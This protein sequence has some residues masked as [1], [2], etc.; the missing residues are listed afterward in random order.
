M[1][2]ALDDIDVALCAFDEHDRVLAWNDTFLEFFPEHAGH[3]EVGE[4]YADNLRRFYT[5]RLSADELPHLHRYV[6]EGLERHRTQRRPYEFDHRGYRLRVS[7]I[8]LDDRGRIRVWRK[9]KD[10]V[11]PAQGHGL[12]QPQMFEV[13]TSLLLE[14]IADGIL[15]VD[16]GDLALWANRAFLRLYDLPAVDALAGLRF[17]DIY[18]RCWSGQVVTTE[19]R[20]SIDTLKENQR[21]SGAPFEIALPAARWVRVIEQR[22]EG[23]DG[24]GYFVHVDITTL[25]RQQQALHMA[26]Q[27]ARDSEARYRLLAEF[28]S[29][30]TV[31]L[32]AG[33][34]TYVS[35]AVFELLGWRPDQMVGKTLESLC[36]PQDVTYV[37]D[38]LHKLKGTPKRDYRARALRADGS[39]VWVEARARLARPYEDEGPL[40]VVN[41]RNVAARKATEDKLAQAL[42]SLKDLA[43]TDALTGVANRRRFD[44]A[45]TSEWRRAH[46]E[47]SPLA[48]MLVDLDRFKTL[49]DT[50]GHQ[51]G[52]LVLRTV[53]E[54]LATFAQ[55]AGEVIARYGGEEFALLLP[56]TKPE[57]ALA[58]ADDARQAVS[59]IDSRSLGLCA[60]VPVTI[61]VG[62]ANSLPF[63]AETSEQ[64]LLRLA[65][66]ALF[67]AKREGR[68]RVVVAPQ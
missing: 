19:F 40:L 45:L 52:D 2:C 67:T 32:A 38:L 14:R 29:D 43:V 56:N 7:A 48:L 50:Y 12:V 11:S 23:A 33:V 62:I 1:G 60:A 30:V 47:C 21:F 41:L 51:A 26:Q 64:E 37:A 28:S 49:N 53:A 10:K 25:K 24:R 13:T 31:A 9:V 57:R 27:Q 65:D 55:R 39:H 35:P 68:N 66:E 16:T 20:A 59:A 46:R 17:D 58:V 18:R 42:A 15:V 6:R 63:A 54:T 36:H 44:E 61:S 5:V 4:P 3:V 34:I 8:E 22:G